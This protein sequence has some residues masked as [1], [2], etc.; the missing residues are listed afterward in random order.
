MK[1]ALFVAA[2][3]VLAVTPS[4]LAQ[5][6][7]DAAA[8]TP[9]VAAPHTQDVSKLAVAPDGSSW[10]GWFDFQP[11]GIQVRVQRLAPDGTQ[12]FDPGGLLVSANP[13]NT[14]T[15]DWDLRTDADGNCILAFTDTRAGGD[16]DVYA[17]FITP[18]GSFLW[19]NDGIPISDN[20]E[21]EADPRIF[22]LSGGDYVVLW[23]RFDVD[24]GIVMQRL[25]AAGNK[26]FPGDGILLY[27]NGSEEPAFIE[28]EPTSDNG[29][30]AAWI[31]NISSFLSP[32][33]VYA[34]GF[35][36]NG[37]ARWG[38]AP[39][40]QIQNAV[41]VPIAHKPRIVTD[42]NDGAWIA[43]HDTRDGD[44]D[45][46]V[47][48]VSRFGQVAFPQNGVA[49][50]TEPARQQLDPAIAIAPNGDLMVFYRNMDG[51]QNQQG[52]NVQRID[53]DGDRALGNAGI[54]LL[55]FNGEYN[56][57]PRAASVAGGVAAVTDLQPTLGNTNGT[58][59]LLRVDESGT[60]LAGSPTGLATTPSQRGRLAVQRAPGGAM[61]AAWT[62]NRNDSV[63]VYAQRVN[64]DGSLGNETN[65]GPDLTGDD[66]IDFFDVL[67]FL[68][69]FANMEPVA[70]FAPDGQFN[71]FDVLAF[72][73]A[74]DEGCP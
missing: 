7:D 1:T 2:A 19:G 26:A 20:T 22:Q 74:F 53:T 11:G 57:P 45:C 70:D 46:Y 73:Q 15:V 33:H 17:Y 60:F 13:Q 32:R 14:S 38:A 16:L 4:A 69:A 44:F 43:W 66:T 42:A 54:A 59:R 41:S 24:P 27:A 21:F 61:I 71:F 48:H 49:V 47:Q 3:G 55:P 58:L 6:S 37:V 50:S 8:N 29:F 52:L 28:A 31:R 30:H 65:C 10:Y 62:D 72:L 12:T 18:D 56:G 9:V 51:A 39:A 67:A 63:D 34:Q 68:Q 23:P 64:A 36:A 40:F 25:D 5:W 35:D